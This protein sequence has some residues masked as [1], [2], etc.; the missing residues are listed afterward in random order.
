MGRGE[1]A[2]GEDI[3]RLRRGGVLVWLGMVRRGRVTYGEDIRQLWRGLL[4]WSWV[5]SGEVRRVE[6]WYGVVGRG[7]LR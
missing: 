3:R 5:S 1:V 7:K 2:Y 6:F 4:R